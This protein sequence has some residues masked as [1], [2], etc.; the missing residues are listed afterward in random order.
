LREFKDGVRK[1]GAGS[2]NNVHPDNVIVN[3]CESTPLSQPLQPQRNV[4]N[5]DYF[6]LKDS[7]YSLNDMF[8][9]VGHSKNYGNLF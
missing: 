6:W 9:E 1:I 4:K 5:F 7:K 8:G 3:A 2:P